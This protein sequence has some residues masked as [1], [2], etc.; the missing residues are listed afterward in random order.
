MQVLFLFLGLVLVLSLP[1]PSLKYH[2]RGWN[3]VNSTDFEVRP[4]RVQIPA[5][6]LTICVNWGCY[7]IPRASGFPSVQFNDYFLLQCIRGEKTTHCGT[8]MALRK[9]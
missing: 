9:C 6:P 5:Q 3:N 4:T 7:I 8:L 2:E 1:S